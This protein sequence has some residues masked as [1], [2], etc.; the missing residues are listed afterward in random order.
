[1]TTT[2]RH[3]APWTFRRFLAMFTAPRRRFIKVDIL[4]GREAVARHLFGEACHWSTLD[5]LE[6]D[7]T[8]RLRGGWLAEADRRIAGGPKISTADADIAEWYGL[9]LTQWDGMSAL[10]KVD[11]REGYAQARGLAS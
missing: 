6:Y 8:P 10:A 1:M 2:H 3:A 5:M 7:N 11:K 4:T 9:T